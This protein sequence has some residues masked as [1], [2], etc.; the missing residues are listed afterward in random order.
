[1]KKV[2]LFAFILSG[3]V[4]C[5][6]QQQ[7]QYQV[8]SDPGGQ[9]VVQ[10]RDNNGINRILEY[11][12]FMRLFGGGHCWSCVYGVG[13]SYYIPSSRISNYSVVKNYNYNSSPNTTSSNTPTT[14]NQ[15]KVNSTTTSN[16]YT[17]SE[18]YKTQSASSTSMPNQKY[19]GNINTNSS[20]K[21]MPTVSRSIRGR[22]K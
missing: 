17:N 2:L 22:R 5:A 11:A 1:M 9:Q 13:S 4:S 20:T 21:S 16:N 19:Q 10:Y 12:M 18:G 14:T 3:T 7:P 15:Q 6:T 8:M